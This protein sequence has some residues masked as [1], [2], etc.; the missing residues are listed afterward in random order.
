MHG[1]LPLNVA[2]WPSSRAQTRLRRIVDQAIRELSLLK[3]EGSG[4]SSSL[5]TEIIGK[6]ARLAAEG[7][8]SA[9]PPEATFSPR[10]SRMPSASFLRFVQQVGVEW[11]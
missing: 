8:S 7:N 11:R 5:V 4:D 1:V 2:R 9:P 10:F 3:A 6:I